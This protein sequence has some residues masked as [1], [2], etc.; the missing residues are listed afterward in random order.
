MN[1]VVKTFEGEK[2]SANHAAAVYLRLKRKL[3]FLKALS[4]EMETFVVELMY[5]RVE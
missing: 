4:V 2:G 5:L 1:V 3:G